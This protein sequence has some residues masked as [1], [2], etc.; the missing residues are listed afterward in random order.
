MNQSTV[1]NSGLR[2]FPNE[3]RFRR[4]HHNDL[5]RCS[6]ISIGAWPEIATFA[7][8]EEMSRTMRSYIDF[9][10]VSATW[11]ETACVSDQIVGFLFGR[12]DCEL[13]MIG[14]LRTSFG[15]GAVY[16]KLLLGLYGHV[17]HRLTIIRSALADDKNIAANSPDADGEVT[18]FVVDS[19]FRGRGI[20]KAL[21]DRFLQHAKIEG[22][23]RMTVYTTDPGCNWGFYERYGFK[24]HA[25]FH[26]N[27][28]SFARKEEVKALIFA[29]DL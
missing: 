20:G 9:C 28:T 2:D 14:R 27:F 25:S 13:G 1:P 21:M 18:F 5:P 7:K 3:M 8:K 4:F 26:D 24:L 23:R 22:A 16:L 15:H 29:V 6:E 10:Q 17:S 11:K 12:I 19:A